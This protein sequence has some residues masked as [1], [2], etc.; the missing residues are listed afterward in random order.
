MLWA[1]L[2]RLVAQL[3]GA[4]CLSRVQ[5][6]IS[7]AAKKIINKLIVESLQAPHCLKSSKLYLDFYV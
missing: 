5:V 6:R 3:D 7:Y 4:W 1:N 2:M